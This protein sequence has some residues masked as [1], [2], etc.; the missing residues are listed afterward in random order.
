MQFG[1]YTVVGLLPERT[2]GSRKVWK[3]LCVCGD[4]RN[5]ITETLT[6]NR[7]KRC[8]CKKKLVEEPPKQIAPAPVK[9]HRPELI[10][11]LTEEGASIRE[12]KA[13]LRSY[14][15]NNRKQIEQFLN[16]AI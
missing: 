10:A 1:I 14:G 15:G 7:S 12:Y 5:V 11:R 4:F 9:L 2:A 3:C 6:K 8:I 13:A 16:K